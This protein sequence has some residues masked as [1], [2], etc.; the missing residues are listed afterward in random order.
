MRSNGLIGAS[1]TDIRCQASATLKSTLDLPC[2]LDMESTM[3]EWM[4]DPRGKQV[5]GSLYAQ[6]EAQTRKMFGES[7]RYGND[8]PNGHSNGG[9]IG[10]DIMDM[11]NDMPVVSVLMFQQ[12]ALTMPAEEIVSGLLRQVQRIN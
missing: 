6:V 8:E 4:A 11:M 7:E 12:S 2:L 5:L 3:R 1:A 10:M 9:G